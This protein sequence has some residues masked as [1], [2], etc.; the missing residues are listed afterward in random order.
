MS[1]ITSGHLAKKKR[2]KKQNWVFLISFFSPH[3]EKHSFECSV[4][5]IFP[6]ISKGLISMED[7]EVRGI[8]ERGI[9]GLEREGE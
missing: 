7:L 6:H 9:E 4:Q 5:L 1:A 8:V 3:F 2:R